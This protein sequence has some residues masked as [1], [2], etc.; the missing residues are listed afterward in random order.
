MIDGRC[1]AHHCRFCVS[2]L[3][4]GDGV[5]DEMKR[6]KDSH[7]KENNASRFHSFLPLFGF[8]VPALI[9]KP[10]ASVTFPNRL[11]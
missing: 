1:L 3:L 11:N 4:L 7:A 10:G 8:Q 9:C 5:G 6:E 2:V